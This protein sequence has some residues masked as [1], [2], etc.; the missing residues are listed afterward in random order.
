MGRSYYVSTVGLSKATIRKYIREQENADIAQDRLN[1]KE[2]E[3][4]FDK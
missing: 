4:P 2:Y 3:N 1:L